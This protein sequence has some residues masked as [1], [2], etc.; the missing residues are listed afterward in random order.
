MYSTGLDLLLWVASFVQHRDLLFILLIRRR[1]RTFPIFAT[2]IVTD[3][4][5]TAALSFHPGL[6]NES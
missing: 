3:I 6:R 4:C 2:L 5:S 1:A